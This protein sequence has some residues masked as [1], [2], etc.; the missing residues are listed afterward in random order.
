M[1]SRER[2]LAAISHREPDRVP[3]DLGGVVSGIHINSYKRLLT[4]LGL[5]DKNIQ[6]Y[7]YN[8]QIV[9]PCEAVL[10]RLHIDTRYLHPPAS[11]VP[12]NFSPLQVGEWIGNYD[13]FGVF[14]GNRASNPPEKRLYYS[15]VI[16]PL[17]RLKT[18]A[19]IHAYDWPKGTDRAVFRG[20][21]ESAQGLRQNTNYAL[22]SRVI[23]CIYEYTTFL[24]GLKLAM[25]Y[26]RTN[27]ELIQAAM[28]ELLTYW[29]DF[30]TTYLEEVGN[31][32]DV[33]CINGDLADQSG[34]LMNPAVY[35]KLIKPIEAEFVKRVRKLTKAPINYHSCGSVIEFLPHFIDIGYSAANP[36]Q[37]SAAGMS[38]ERLKRDFGAKITF[39]GGACDSQKT[40][41]FGTPAQVRA[42]V[43]QNLIAFKPGG[44][45]VASNVHNITGEVPAENILAMFDALHEYG[46]Y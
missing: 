43:K 11:Y 40:L 3:I 23:G 25:R 15:P 42:E 14:W 44:G 26:F 13:Q 1:N 5:E 24:F 2:V 31:N 35:A 10:E 32:V 27:P 29:T 30:A 21:K 18:V 12:E 6:F 41:P 20:L 16:H 39:W 8:Q 38:P 9:T 37:I 4:L 17:A 34:P 7:D 19:E 45:Y 46:E 28:E 22:V 33:I 36:V